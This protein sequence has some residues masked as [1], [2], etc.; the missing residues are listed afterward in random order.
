MD[1]SSLSAPLPLSLLPPNLVH[2][3]LQ[4]LN[5]YF[6]VHYATAAGFAFYLYDWSES[7][8]ISAFLIDEFALINILTSVL[9]FDDEV[10]FFWG[11]HSSPAKILFFAN[12]YFALLSIIGQVSSMQLVRNHTFSSQTLDS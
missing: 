7:L 6:I 10:R 2:Q 1:T 11:T 9:T 4:A 12:R 8:S 5:H 3:L